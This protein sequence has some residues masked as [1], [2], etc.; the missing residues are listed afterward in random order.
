MLSDKNVH[1]IVNNLFSVV[2]SKIFFLSAG[3]LAMADCHY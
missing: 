3:E 2:L 1:L